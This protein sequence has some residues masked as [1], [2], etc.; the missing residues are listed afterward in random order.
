MLRIDYQLRPADLL[1]AIG[2]M[3]ELSAEKISAIE[4]VWANRHDA[5]VFTVQGRYTS[6]AWTDWTQGFQYGS[7]LLQFDATGQEEFLQLGRRGTLTKM[8]LHL[9]HIGVHD[10]GFNNVSTY[11]NLWR[12]MAEGRLPENPSERVLYE[13][14]LKVSGAVQAARWMRTADG[15][16]YIYSFN[17]PHS[18]F[19]DTIRSLRSL[20]LAH[21]LGHRLC[22][23]Q[24]ER[25]SLLERLV[26]HAR[27]TARYNIY[28]GQGRD[29]YDVR[30]RV[31]HESLFNPR[32]GQY[33]C[34]ST[35]QGYSPFS[36]WT[37][38]LAWVILGYAELLEWLDSRADEE[39]EPFGGRPELEEFMLEAARATADFYIQQTPTDG[40]P[41]WDTGAPGL[42][43]LGDYLDRPADPF[44]RY[45][46][47]DSSAAAIACQG[48]LRLGHY[49]SQRG[50]EHTHSAP[51]NHNMEEPFQNR[52]P[53]Q[54]VRGC[55]AQPSAQTELLAAGP[56]VPA[57]VSEAVRYFQAGLTVLRTL[58]SE[59]YLSTQP[60][61]QGLLL[62]AVY[63][64][65]R[66]WDYVPPGHRIPHG[67]S[68]MWGDY[69][70][71]EVVLY[72]GRLA[73]G[74]PYHCF[75][76]P[77]ERKKPPA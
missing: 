5:P 73:Q 11:G 45:E 30:G 54:V 31:A 1:A 40:I 33:R 61:H 60:D 64:R 39:L 52:S 14:A 62:H 63:H 17:G 50:T 34:P 4:Q 21:Q 55:G 46:P 3:W 15:L 36:T 76:G 7:A 69:H 32:T 24:D 66:G 48:L 35:Q 77:H 38:G 75:F 20:A 41:Y 49:L 37:R 42:R 74:A 72:L 53:A 18:L 16:G 23:E 71:R 27:T 26:H 9:T 25:I 56:A 12:L 8:A 57:P 58:L 43:Y 44:N 29:I 70:L 68:C 2:R 51:A 22:G 6:Q 65:P 47:V 67:E 19:C 10:H 28:Y 59:P 13:Q